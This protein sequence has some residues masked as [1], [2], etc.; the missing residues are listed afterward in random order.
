MLFCKTKYYLWLRS[1][2]TEMS[3]CYE[4]KTK[5]YGLIKLLKNALYNIKFESKA[6]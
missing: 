5:P 6:C 2:L 3:S 4:A 1:S